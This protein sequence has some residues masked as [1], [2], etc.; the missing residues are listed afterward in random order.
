[1][2]TYDIELQ[3]NNQDSVTAEERHPA[4]LFQTKNR[5][6]NTAGS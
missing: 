2:T 3:K 4:A 1:M 5:R 6:L